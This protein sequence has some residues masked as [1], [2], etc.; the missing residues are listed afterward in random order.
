MDRSEPIEAAI[1]E[2]ASTEAL[3]DVADAARGGRSERESSAPATATTTRALRYPDRQPMRR[4]R[5]E[6]R[7]VPADRERD[8][9]SSDPVSHLRCLEPVS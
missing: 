1:A 4:D 2:E 6:D 9:D 5:P 7:D 3:A 8:P